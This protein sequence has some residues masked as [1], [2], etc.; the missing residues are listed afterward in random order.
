MNLAV[1][2]GKRRPSGNVSHRI[3]VG[4]SI[5]DGIAQL[6]VLPLDVEKSVITQVMEPGFLKNLLQIRVVH[7]GQARGQ[8]RQGIG[9][10]HLSHDHAQEM[11]EL[12]ALS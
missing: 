5:G 3:A 10:G 4:E 6:W 7:V 1:I 9:V 11:H 2:V 8:N 12:L